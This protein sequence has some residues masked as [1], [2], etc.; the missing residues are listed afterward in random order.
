[1]SERQYFALRYAIP[2]YVFILIVIALNYVPLLKILEASGISDVFGAFLA[3]FSLFSGSAIG[4]LVSQVWWFMW[5]KKC[6]ILGEEAYDTSI[7]AFC[8]NYGLKNPKSISDKNDKREF[9]T[10]LDYVCH[11]CVDEKLVKVGERRWDIYHVLSSAFHTLWIGLIVGIAIRL[12]Y[13]IYLFSRHIQIKNLKHF[14]D[15]YLYDGICYALNEIAKNHLTAQA[16]F[17]SFI[18]IVFIT[19][20]MLLILW[21]S[22]RWTLTFSASL[23]EAIIRSS[24]VKQKDLKKA[25]KRLYDR[26][27]KKP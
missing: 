13:G 1:M 15:T 3:F 19:A 23:H 11:F 25:F 6:G 10:A 17:V 26:Y 22:R 18:G 21:F 7:K 5:Q 24:C 2:G 9:I 16:E 20:L 4:F 14:F 8:E 27:S 12:Y